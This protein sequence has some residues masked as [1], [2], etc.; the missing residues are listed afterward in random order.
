MDYPNLINTYAFVLWFLPALFLGRLLIHL[1][2]TKT[3]SILIQFLIISFLFYS[4][5]YLDLYFA[6]DNAFNSILFIFLGSVFYKLYNDEKTLYA[7]ILILPI[8]IFYFG[9]PNLNMALKIFEH[10]F[11]NIMFASSVI[12]IL[13]KLVNRL[14]L[15]SKLI[16]LWG[17]NTM[18]L[19]I[20]HPYTNHI[21][22]IIFGNDILYGN[23]HMKFITSLII[24]QFILFLKQRF[25]NRGIFKYV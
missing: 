17:A 13:I 1:I 18:I 9:I 8:L 16:T 12:F 24:L 22:H 15:N 21:G 19:F 5:F 4:S 3:K 10:V 14:H 6:I 23:W 2:G 25:L 11:I 7:L 20:I